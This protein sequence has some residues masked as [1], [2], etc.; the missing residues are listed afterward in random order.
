M[1]YRTAPEASLSVDLAARP[2]V[3]AALPVVDIGSFSATAH[4]FTDAEAHAEAGRC[5]RCDAVYGCPSVQVVAGRGPADG[6]AARDRDAIPIPAAGPADQ[7]AQ[8]GV[9]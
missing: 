5:F 1:R 2:R 8:G 7:P 3:H 4:G 6:R 9:Q